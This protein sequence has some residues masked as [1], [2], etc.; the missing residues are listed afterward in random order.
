MAVKDSE[1]R[2][3]LMKK[4]NGCS[5]LKPIAIDNMG[6]IYVNNHDEQTDG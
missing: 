2:M 3:V 6:N 4:I 1:G 5:V